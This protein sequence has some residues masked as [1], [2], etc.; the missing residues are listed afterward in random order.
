MSQRTLEEI[1]D[2]LDELQQSY[3]DEE[4]DVR[5]MELERKFSLFLDEA[6]EI[7]GVLRNAVGVTICNW[8][9]S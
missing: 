6:T 4:D 1:E 2:E 5:Q 9:R 3:I 7:D 8:V